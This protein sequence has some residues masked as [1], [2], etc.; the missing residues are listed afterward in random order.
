LSLPGGRLESAALALV[1]R[2]GPDAACLA[3]DCNPEGFTGSRW[4]RYA[5]NG[6]DASP[7]P[8]GL[9]NRAIGLLKLNKARDANLYALEALRTCL[10]PEAPIVLFGGNDE[11]IK[12]VR[13][14]GSV[15]FEVIDSLGHGRLLR[16]A[17]GSGPTRQQRDFLKSAEVT[18]P[19][20]GARAWTSYPGCF[21]QG[22]VDA[23]TLLLLQSLDT[24]A[25]AL[26]PARVLDFACGTGVIAADVSARWPSAEVEG[27]DH[28]AVAVS[29]ARANVP[30]ARF[31]VG[32]G[33]SCIGNQMFD[34]VLSNPPFHDGKVRSHRV[35]MN[36]VSAVRQRLR[37]NG[38]VRVVV[39]R[40]VPMEGPLRDAFTQVD[41]LVLHPR[42]AIWSARA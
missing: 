39:Q 6:C 40:E 24:N 22:G 19:A 18:L 11:G 30:R 10:L 25:P 21:A 12:S 7:W 36:F 26:A 32:D 8:T 15:S 31:V 27:C 4:S 23:G 1:R 20:A 9:A 14:V 41:R 5:G 29:A 34:L 13:Q 42:F 38:E 16:G 17:T 37:P 3:V 35:W 2:L 33:L 28:D